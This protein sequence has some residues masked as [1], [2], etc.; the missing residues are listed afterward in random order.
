M[1]YPY[2]V[3]CENIK[4]IFFLLCIFS[5]VAC[6]SIDKKKN[7]SSI[8]INKQGISPK[9]RPEMASTCKG[10]ILTK[11]QVMDFYNNSTPIYNEM[12][13]KK[14]NILPCYSEG[15]AYLHGIKYQWRIRSG[16]FGEFYNEK[17]RIF[18]VCGEN[19]C[20]KVIGIC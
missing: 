2:D 4:M 15:T 11:K 20:K 16:G 8:D 17:K 7:I 13:S 14:Y 9:N 12:V 18:K 6:S 1:K 5:V 19:C 3:L 10:F